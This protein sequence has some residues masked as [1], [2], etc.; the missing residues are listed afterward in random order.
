MIFHIIHGTHTYNQSNITPN[1]NPFLS[2]NTHFFA[3]SIIFTQLKM[4]CVRVHI[5]IKTYKYNL[6]AWQKYHPVLALYPD[7][8]FTLIDCLHKLSLKTSYIWG[9]GQA[10]KWFKFHALHFGGPRV[11]RIRSQAPIYTLLIKP[12]CPIHKVEEDW[13]GYWLRAHLP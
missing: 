6:Y 2:T 1:S 7:I 3:F 4:V 10:A 13:H 5:I 11:H 8:Q 12:C 9:A